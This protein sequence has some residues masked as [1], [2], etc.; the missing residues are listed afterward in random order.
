MNILIVGKGWVGTKVYY[1]LLT[2]KKLNV[3]QLHR[4]YHK[5]HTEVWDFLNENPIIDWVINCAG[6]TGVPNVDAC[7]KDKAN[8]LYG[9]VIFPVKLGYECLHRGI[10]YAHFSSGCIYEGV[11]EDVNATPNFFGSTYSISKGIS[12]TAL[13]DIAQVYRIRMPFTIHKEPKNYLVKVRKYATTGKLFEGGLNS[14]T[15]VEEAV[16]VACNLIERNAPNGRYN[17]VNKGAVTLHQIIEMFGLKG[18]WYT[19]EE[20]RSVTACG[21]SNCTIPSYEE[22]SDVTTALERAIK[23]LYD[24]ELTHDSVCLT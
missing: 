6:V 21:R 23:E 19:E 11:I 7:E 22:M 3:N 16:R 12:D 1:E 15:D 9:N 8:T 14:L 18:D 5:S 17:L 2:R 10:R 20:F 4:L 13:G 24:Q